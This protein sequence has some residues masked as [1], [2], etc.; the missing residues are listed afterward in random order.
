M[1]AVEL[2]LDS[3]PI[4]N[5]EEDAA[6]DES[7]YNAGAAGVG[8]IRLEPVLRKQHSTL[9]AQSDLSVVDY[10]ARFEDMAAVNQSASN[11]HAHGASASDA[12]SVPVSELSSVDVELLAHLRGFAGHS[13]REKD[14]SLV[15][16]TP[17]HARRRIAGD[18]DTVSGLHVGL[19][20]NDAVY[21]NN[22]L[23]QTLNEDKESRLDARSSALS[24]ATYSEANYAADTGDQLGNDTA[25]RP[26]LE[27]LLLSPGGST[28]PD[29]L[30][31][32]P[33]DL[34]NP[35]SPRVRTPLSPTRPLH[36]S[37]RRTV[38]NPNYRSVPHLGPALLSERKST[39]GT[40]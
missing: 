29:S 9:D 15:P 27:D 39:S 17:P 31:W 32:S 7:R 8:P 2:V 36:R 23:L 20:L 25:G 35:L 40:A 21:D 6:Q 12:G 19:D 24:G 10:V 1:E 14:D 26:S 30:D 18:D 34:E 16:S 33:S 3:A 22:R 5:F 38:E 11:L 37:A 4:L 13:D 28:C